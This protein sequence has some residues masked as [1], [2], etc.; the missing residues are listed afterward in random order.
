[1]ETNETVIED[2]A[3]KALQKQNVKL[4]MAVRELVR[5]GQTPNQVDRFI[6]T[7]FGLKK[8]HPVRD[9]CYFAAKS[10][11][12]ATQSENFER[13]LEAGREMLK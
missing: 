1:M 8:G 6:A 5:T 7:R 12:R 10:L 13:R 2:A 9:L 4:L 3:I 11:S